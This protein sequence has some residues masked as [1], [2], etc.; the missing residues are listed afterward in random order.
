MPIA[1]ATESEE[2]A[3]RQMLQRFEAFDATRAQC[4][5][6]AERQRLLAGLETGFGSLQQFNNLVAG[7]FASGTS[8]SARNIRTGS[9]KLWDNGAGTLAPSDSTNG[10]PRPIQV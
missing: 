8:R 1:S 4:F 9:I 6:E 3:Q 2:E 5:V 10:L 7:I